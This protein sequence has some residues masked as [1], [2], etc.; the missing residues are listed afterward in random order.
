MDSMTRSDLPWKSKSLIHA[1]EGFWPLQAIKGVESI[2]KIETGLECDQ[3][4]LR[5]L[6]ITVPCDRMRGSKREHTH[7][8][9]SL[10]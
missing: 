1:A 2:R 8:I 5:K 6:R 7:T 10:N 9:A 4:L 3:Q